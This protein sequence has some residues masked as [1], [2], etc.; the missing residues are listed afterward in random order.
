MATFY[1]DYEGGNDA[2][3]GTTF[4]NR[5][6][7]TTL[8]ATAARIAPG[9]TIRIM[10]SPEPTLVGSCTWTNNSE[11]MTIPSGIAKDLLSGVEGNG[12][13]T[14]TN[15][16]A[17]SGSIIHDTYSKGFI[18]ASGFTTGKVAYR[19]LGSTL[20]LS[21]Y[22]QMCCWVASTAALSASVL[23][24]RLCS[25]TTG[26]VTVNTILIPAI[27]STLNNPVVVDTGANFGSSIQSIAIYAESDPG[28][29]TLSIASFTACKASS[30]PDAIT[31]NSLIGKVH[32][33]PWVASTSYAQD[34]KVRPTQPNRNGYQYK[35]QNSGSHSTS[36][37]EPT[38]PMG[39]GQTVVDGGVT[40]VCE[41][42][43]DTWHPVGHIKGTTLTFYAGPNA[44]ST[45]GRTYSGITET[46]ATYKRE[47]ILTIIPASSGTVIHN[48]MESG[49]DAARMTYT[50]G[51][52][53]TDMSTQTGETWYSGQIGWG[54][55]FQASS[56]N[57]VNFYNIN[58]VR[59]SVGFN[60]FSV[61]SNIYNC[62]INGNGTAFQYGT[63]GN[64]G[65]EYVF[66]GVQT[67]HQNAFIV[68]PLGLV[69][70]R[71][72][73]SAGISG[74]AMTLANASG[75]ST[76][77]TAI[78]CVYKNA[79]GAGLS[80]GVLDFKGYN[81]ILSDNSA[82]GAVS[83]KCDFLMVNATI[84]DAVKGLISVTYSDVYGKFEK[85]NGTV[86]NHLIVT[87]GGSISSATDQRHTAS[88]ISWKFNPTSVLRTVDYPKMSLSVAKV[89]VASGSLV[90][91]SI[92]TRRDN[93][94]I[95]GELYIAGL[96]LAG[97]PVTG[98]TTACSPSI[99]T[100]TQY[101]ITFTPTEAG[102]VELQFR[103]WDGVG[104]TNSYW[105]DDFTV[106]QA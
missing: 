79:S 80:L 56:I 9:D 96:Q 73:K 7:T 98:V 99:N 28:A 71:A 36:A 42:L 41:E 91:M 54:N 6:K 78:D 12:W 84:P 26:D 66:H 74:A 51:W 3:D 5:W 65:S 53:R 29:I 62:H 52:N 13:T 83:A 72:V 48:C 63:N 55:A 89:A 85:L 17:T 8:G 16:T 25:D 4:A 34:A 10:A 76:K 11:T 81:C 95:N 77:V 75:Q 67:N 31:F 58:L 61:K 64:N 101:S 70:M 30:S 37:S 102:V 82:T 44:S 49:T 68:S 69:Y 45:K 43:E 27:N 94:N 104:T 24:I 23:S 18:I 47:P 2:N 105:I 19:L 22:Q 93:T 90:T 86:D 88:G 60:I 50:G 14:T 46:V 32:N 39:Y 38:W 87:D 106:T 57:Y 15:V 1:L 33:L 40:W 20:D 97:I 21:T 103:V 92:W 59:Y 100:W 35:K